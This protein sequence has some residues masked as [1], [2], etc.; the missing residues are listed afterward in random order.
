[1]E[2]ALLSNTLHEFRDDDIEGV[3]PVIA[4]IDAKRREWSQVLKTIDYFDK[5]GTLPK[6][7]PDQ[8]IMASIE[9]KEGVAE[10]Q[11]E[12]NRLSVNIS[13]YTKKLE[14]TPEHKKAEQ[15]REDLAKME[16]MK[17]ELRKDIINLNYASK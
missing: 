12:I 17:N 14:T 5:T 2:A 6:Q 4:Q 7:Q 13:K 10:L 1:M 8:S 16:A 3:R 9:K 15:W 11:L